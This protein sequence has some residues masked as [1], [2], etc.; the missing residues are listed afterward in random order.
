MQT[1]STASERITFLLLLTLFGLLSS[2]CGNSTTL[3][4]RAPHPPTPPAQLLTGVGASTISFTAS[5]GTSASVIISANP[6]SGQGALTS[7]RQASTKKFFVSIK[8]AD[9]QQVLLSFQHYGGHGTYQVKGGVKEDAVE[10][11]LG[12]QRTIWLLNVKFQ[13][14][15]TLV[16]ASDTVVPGNT[17]EVGGSP[18]TVKAVDEVKGTLTCPSLPPLAAGSPPLQVSQGSFDVFMDQLA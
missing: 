1:H 8:G 13:G 9:Q 15:C 12:Q 7:Y 4:P 10:V 3:A 14:N 6:R 11:T 5:G 17:T 16:V 2:A 18:G